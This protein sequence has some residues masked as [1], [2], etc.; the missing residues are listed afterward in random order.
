MFTEKRCG[1]GL[2]VTLIVQLFRLQFAC[3]LYKD[4]SQI[5]PE[6]DGSASLE[7]TELSEAQSVHVPRSQ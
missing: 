2:S 6:H 4:G 7:N 1:I 5:L 3:S